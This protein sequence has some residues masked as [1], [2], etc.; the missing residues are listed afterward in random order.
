MITIDITTAIAAF[1]SFCLLLVFGSW[2]FYN[3][4]ET[5]KSVN[6]DQRIIQCPYCSHLFTETRQ[7]LIRCPQCKSVL[8]TTI[9]ISNNKND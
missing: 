4:N 1:L 3:F 8:D 5:D 9:H 6:T 7:D 2:I